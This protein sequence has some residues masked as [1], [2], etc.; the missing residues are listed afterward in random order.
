MQNRARYTALTDAAGLLAP[1]VALTS[2][3]PTSILVTITPAVG[4]TATSY[5]IRYSSV[6]GTFTD[7]LDYTTID[8]T[9]TFTLA[10]LDN[11][12]TYHF[13]VA[14]LNSY[15]NTAFSASQS[16]TTGIEFE[17]EDNEDGRLSASWNSVGLTDAVNDTLA[18]EKSANGTTGWATVGSLAYNATSG[19]ATINNPAISHYYRLKAYRAS[20]NQTFYSNVF[21]PLT[22]TGDTDAAA[23]ITEYSTA[24]YSFGAGQ[25]TAIHTLYS[26]LKAQSRYTMVRSALA[27]CFGDEDYNLIPLIGAYTPTQS[28]MTVNAKNETGGASGFID[29]NLSPATAFSDGNRGLILYHL[30]AQPAANTGLNGCVGTGATIVQFGVRFSGL[31]TFVDFGGYR[32]SIA[33]TGLPGLYGFQRTGS[34]AVGRITRY[35]GTQNDLGAS[36][37]GAGS[38]AQP[39]T[40][41]WWFGRN[42]GN[43]DSTSQQT[44]GLCALV[45][46][47][48]PD[49]CDAISEIFWN[50]LVAFG[51]N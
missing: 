7:P 15:G 14:A 24:G 16:I 3:T 23:K 17:A 51:A 45:D 8:R 41:F 36:T 6:N 11:G 1:T 22:I 19:F 9:A 50:F 29:N 42:N 10:G 2:P 18:I 5:R 32:T 46:S 38:E 39:A 49:D 33:D 28:D 20:D 30:K 25:Q 37:S 48:D 44:G 34:G 27:L 4:T 31:G 21:G 40:D 13:S 26:T 43:L 47:D 12:E 35:D